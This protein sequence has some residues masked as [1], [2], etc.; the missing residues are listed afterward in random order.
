[1]SKRPADDGQRELLF[2]VKQKA[3]APS[4]KSACINLRSPA[5]A[6]TRQT[7]CRPTGYHSG[8]S[9]QVDRWSVHSSLFYFIL[10]I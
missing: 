3:Y 9:N 7:A 5:A 2:S 8:Q 10:F 4:I 6:L 1:M